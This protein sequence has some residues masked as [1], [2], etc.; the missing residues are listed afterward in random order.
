[1]LCA[2][3]NV[4]TERKELDEGFVNLALFRPVQWFPTNDPGTTSAP[5]TVLEYLR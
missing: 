5:Q 3:Q 2:W 1:M 4:T